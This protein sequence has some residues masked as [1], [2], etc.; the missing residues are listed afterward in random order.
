MNIK[1]ILLIGL[2]FNIYS[3]ISQIGGEHAFQFLDLN[4]NA[5][6]TALGG[7]FSAV[8]DN[9]INLSITNPASINIEMNNDVAL[10]HAFYPAGINFG[11]LIVGHKFDK[12]GMVTMHMRYVAYGRFEGTDITG[13]STGHFTAGDYALGAGYGRKLNERFSVGANLNL[14]LSQYESYFSFGSGIDFSVMYFNAEKQLTATLLARNVGVQFK[15]YTK[16][17]REPLPIE[18]LAG[19]SYRLPH[20]PFRFSLTTHDLNTWDLAYTP[21]NQQ[22]TVDPLS[23][24]DTIPVK[25][26]SFIEKTFRHANLGVEILPTDNFSLRLGYNFNSRQNY[27]IKDRFSITG[28]S[29]GVGFRV[30]KLDFNYSVVFDSPAGSTNMLS[31]T[32]NFA[33]W[34]KK[35]T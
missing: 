17:N 22:P 13:A 29:T 34:R 19:I 30:K 26:T 20:A 32:S 15:G 35:R 16:K 12:I 23:P 10:N 24:T 2:I 28:F 25:K 4:F 31:I 6:S 21:P 18:L 14:I 5:R 7:D 33:N 11:Q 27:F 3:A 1:A 9:D 8:N